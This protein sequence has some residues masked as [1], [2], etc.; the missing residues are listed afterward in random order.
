MPTGRRHDV[1]KSMPEIMKNKVSLLHL[2]GLGRRTE[3]E[4]QGGYGE[5][6]VTISPLN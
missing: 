6:L 3:G 5:K 4:A 2:R 1:G